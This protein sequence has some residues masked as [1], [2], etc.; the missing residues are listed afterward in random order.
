MIKLFGLFA[1]LTGLLSCNSAATNKEKE[2]L[3]IAEKYMHAVESKNV[4]GMD[5]LLSE[6][7]IGRGPS[8]GDSVNKKEAMA[9]FASNAQNLYESCE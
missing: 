1:F 6:N 3:A 5:S 8:V 2:H 9:T 4:A 7:Y